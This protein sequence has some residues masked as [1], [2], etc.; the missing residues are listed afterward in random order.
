M[1]LST[2]P[3]LAEQ[4]RLADRTGLEIVVDLDDA[5]FMDCAGMRPLLEASLA[6]GPA[7]FSVTSGPPQIQRLFQFAGII[8]VL[9]TAR[10]SLTLGRVAA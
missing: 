4:I 3:F 2:A 7:R 5:T 1:D 9:R 8:G 6:M 10:R